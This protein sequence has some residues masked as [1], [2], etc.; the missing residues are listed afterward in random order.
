MKSFIFILLGILSFLIGLVSLLLTFVGLLD[1][2]G[3]D[4]FF[5]SFL[6]TV[7]VISF[8]LGQFL[9]NSSRKDKKL[10]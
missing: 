1:P 5:V 9:L 4:K 3:I 6:A 8:L 7:A 10:S 2:E